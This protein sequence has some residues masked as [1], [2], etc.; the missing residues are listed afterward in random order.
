MNAVYTARRARDPE[1]A[2]GRDDR[3]ESPAFGR[4]V[5]M[6]IPMKVYVTCPIAEL[7]Q[8][9]GTL[10]AVSP[11]GYYE[12]HVDYGANTHSILVP[13]SATVLTAIDP[14][15]RPPPSFEVER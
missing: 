6:D 11:H 15:L 1:R 14:I 8:V 2:S 12:I 10:I 13:V 9:P 5:A 4:R 3:I 7:K